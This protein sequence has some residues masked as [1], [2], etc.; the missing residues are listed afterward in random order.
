MLV[1]GGLK[2]E[3]EGDRQCLRLKDSEKVHVIGE[4]NCL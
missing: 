4:L 3:G 1:T 2:G